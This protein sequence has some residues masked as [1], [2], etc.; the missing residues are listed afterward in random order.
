MIMGG[1]M[2]G[3]ALAVATGLSLIFAMPAVFAQANRDYWRVSGSKDAVTY[4]DAGSIAVVTGD[5]KRALTSTYYSADGPADLAGD[6]AIDLFEYDCGN[7]RLRVLQTKGYDSHGSIAWSEEDPEA[8]F[9]AAPN[10]IAGRQLE[11]VCWSPVERALLGLHLH[12][13]QTP[14]SD[15]ALVFRPTAGTSD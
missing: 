5:I 14:E 12:E 10:S 15:A 7:H 9:F 4:V 13:G 2:R 11:F 8:W 1:E 6:S 3:L